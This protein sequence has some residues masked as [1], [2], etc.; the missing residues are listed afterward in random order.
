MMTHVTTD[1]ERRVEIAD[2]RVPQKKSLFY[3]LRGWFRRRF[4][5]KRREQVVEGNVEQKRNEQNVES[6]KVMESGPLWQNTSAEVLGRES[7]ADSDGEADTTE[8]DLIPT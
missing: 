6:R 4:G 5:A 7:C 2:Q 8:P 3:C 1:V